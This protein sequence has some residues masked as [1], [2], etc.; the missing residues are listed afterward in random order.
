MKAAYCFHW[1]GDFWP[2]SRYL[3]NGSTDLLIFCGVAKY[4]IDSI[5]HPYRPTIDPI[6]SIDHPYELYRPS[7]STLSTLS[8]FPIEPIDPIY[9]SYRPS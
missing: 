5:D 3:P 1:K 7:L 6:D 2:A 9:L 8:T 4:C